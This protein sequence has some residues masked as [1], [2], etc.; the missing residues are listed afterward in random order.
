MKTQRILVV[1]VTA[2]ILIGITV[3]QVNTTGLSELKR[4]SLLIVHGDTYF[5][6][7]VV[8]ILKDSLDKR[9]DTILVAS[10]NKMTAIPSRKF[11]AVV[12]LH[13]ID[14]T[15][16]S[17]AAQEFL[18]RYPDEYTNTNVLVC[19]VRGEKWTSS[20]SEVNTVTSATKPFKPDIVA[21]KILRSIN[22]IL[23][24]SN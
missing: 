8:T 12:M 23:T 4:H 22:Q 13:A 24:G 9:G 15:Q 11:G 7:A 6:N 21:A 2:A 17:S 19:N 20:A 5:E 10:I 14:K 16:L 3:A 1:L 18:K